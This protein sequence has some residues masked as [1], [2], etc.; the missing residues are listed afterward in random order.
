MEKMTLKSYAVKH[1][2]SIFNVMKMVK[3]G[4]VKSETVTEEGREVIY[5]LIDEE[6]EQEIEAQIVPVEQKEE[7][8]VKEQILF[9]RKELQLLKE[10]VQAIK[11]SLS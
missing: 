11:K 6:N 2:L 4:K 1:K 10:E 3:A 5:I 9:L 8:Q 7:M